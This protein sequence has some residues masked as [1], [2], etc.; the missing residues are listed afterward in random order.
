MGAEIAEPVARYRRA[1]PRDYRARYA[2]RVFG[3]TPREVALT[4]S[5]LV[6]TYGATPEDV[7][8]IQAEVEGLP[9]DLEK[10]AAFYF[11]GEVWMEEGDR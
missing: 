6:E 3:R 2:F 4:V 1:I 8:E 9:F 5:Y 10:F 7:I 11:S